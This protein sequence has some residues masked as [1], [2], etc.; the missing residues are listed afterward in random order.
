MC[1]AG[2][3]CPPHKPSKKGAHMTDGRWQFA[4]GKMRRAFPGFSPFRE[5][6]KVGVVGSRRG[7]SG[8]AYEAVIEVRASSFPAKKPK[9]FINPW[10]ALN[11][12]LD[13]SLC[14][15]RA[16]RPEQDTMAQ[17]VL[18]AVDYLRTRG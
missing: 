5:G 2:I 16:W 17:Q 12:H 1:G 18:F 7:K 3:A 14:V 6:G 9:I 8:K 4:I 11:R 10:V 13:G 15:E